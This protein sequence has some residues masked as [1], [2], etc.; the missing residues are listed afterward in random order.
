MAGYKIFTPNKRYCGK[1]YDVKFDHGEAF[2]DISTVY[3]RFS[4]PMPSIQDQNFRP[5]DYY[6]SL[7]S[8]SQPTAERAA[9]FLAGDF[10]YTSVYIP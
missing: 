9:K 8:R 7:A 10:G 5:N 3:D 1:T 6:I 4:V 2:L